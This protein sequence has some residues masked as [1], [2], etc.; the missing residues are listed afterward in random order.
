MNYKGHI[1]LYNHFAQYLTLKD[2]NEYLYFLPCY[3]QYICHWF[4]YKGLQFHE[5]LK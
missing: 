5:T 3:I 2:L 4:L 1:P